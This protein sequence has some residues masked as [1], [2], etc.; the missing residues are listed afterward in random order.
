M[1]D[2]EASLELHLS[3]HNFLELTRTVFK[4]HRNDIPTVGIRGIQAPPGAIPFKWGPTVHAL[5]LF[6]VKAAAIADDNELYRP[7]L[8]GKSPSPALNIARLMGRQEP[9]CCF[10][11]FGV[12]KSGRSN[13]SRMLSICNHQLRDLRPVQLYLRTPPLSPTGIRVWV[14]EDEVTG[15]R[16]K[17]TALAAELASAWQPGKSGRD[18]K[19]PTIMRK[20]S[21]DTAAP[22]EYSTRP[23]VI[24]VARSS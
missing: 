19:I 16:E 4:L 9:R 14:D 10:D 22:R 20:F 12:D 23:G 17:L 15:N 13:I 3:K 11:L 18:G 21:K 7:C 1:R 6:F 2:A 24:K 5:T 8:Q